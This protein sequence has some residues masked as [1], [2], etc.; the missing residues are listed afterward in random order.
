MSETSPLSRPA[1]VL[2]DMDGTLIDSEVLWLDAELAMLSRY[3]IELTQE[4]RD[5]MVGSGLRAAADIFRELGVQMTVAEIIAEWQDAV[6]AGLLASAP[7]WRPGAIELLAS[8]NAVG[9]PSALVT[10]SLRTIADAVVAMLPSGSFVAIVG[11]DEVVMEKPHP[12]A[13]L[14]GAVLLGVPIEHCLA[15]EDSPAGLRSAHASGA[16]AIGVPNHVDLAQAPSHELWQTLAGVGAD[17]LAERFMHLRGS[18]L[19]KTHHL[20]EV[21]Q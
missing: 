11:G 2:W 5:Q 9:I 12:E 20:T 7:V 1:A 13:Y 10:M 18:A 14:R 19:E 3:D 21:L 16:V 8:L 17:T 15:I 4:L 6:I